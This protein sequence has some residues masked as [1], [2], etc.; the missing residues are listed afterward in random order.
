MKISSLLQPIQKI[1]VKKVNF[2]DQEIQGLA[3][4]YREITEKNYFFVS[5]KK[6]LQK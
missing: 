5:Q 4:D 3:L 1:I 2:Q 6:N